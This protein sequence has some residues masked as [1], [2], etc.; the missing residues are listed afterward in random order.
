MDLHCVPDSGLLFAACDASP[1]NTYYI[2]DFGP[3]PRWASFLDNV[4]EEMA[5]DPTSSTAYQDYK[6][7]DRAE[8]ETLGLTHLIGTPAL[9]PYMHGFFLALKLYQTAR[10]IANPQSYAEHREKIVEER[11]AKKA[12]SRIRAKRE[13]PKVNKALAERLRKEQERLDAVE[14]RKAA[15]RAERAA[16]NGEA[17]EPAEAEGEEEGEGEGKKEKSRKDAVLLDP[18]FAEMFSNPDFEIDE[19]S[20]TFQLLNP[21]TSHNARLRTAVEEEEDDSDRSSAGLSDDES[22]PESE[23]EQES[24]PEEESDEEMDEDE[25]EEEDSG[26]GEEYSDASASDDEVAQPAKSAFPLAKGAKPKLQGATQA[27][28][29]T[30]GQ[31]LHASRKPEKDEKPEG[32]LAMRRSADGGMEMSFIP[33]SGGRGK[34]EDEDDEYGGGGYRRRSKVETFGAGLEKGG[35]EEEDE[36]QGRNGRTK[37]RHIE[38]S[39]SKNAFRRR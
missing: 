25:A 7:V 19:E 39:A 27:K 1:L 23:P 8:L 6:F 3:A 34:L 15:K 29:Q 11:L 31:R 17:V 26:D 24:E 28:P 36:M 13:Q 37:R 32:V 16:A 21:A 10:L 18:R 35:H 2:P 14:A 9:R 38:R 33:K 22:E 4:T 20:K 30:F 5:D 12:E